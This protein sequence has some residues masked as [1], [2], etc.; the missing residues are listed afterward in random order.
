LVASLGRSERR[1]AASHCGEAWWPRNSEIQ[2][3]YVGLPPDP[4]YSDE[5]VAD[6]MAAGRKVYPAVVQGQPEGIS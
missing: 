3:R 6:I 2:N 1:W 5:D 4:K